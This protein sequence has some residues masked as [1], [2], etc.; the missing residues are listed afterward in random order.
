M[1]LGILPHNAAHWHVA[2]NHIPMVGF[3][4]GFLILGL[5]EFSSC[6]SW[7]KVGWFIIFVAAVFLYPVVETG[8]HAEEMV[9]KLENVIATQIHHH[10]EKAELA[11]WCAGITGVFAFIA[12]IAEA[13]RNN[14]LIRPFRL[15]ILLGVLS[16]LVFFLFA[17]YEGGLIRHPEF[18]E[19]TTPPN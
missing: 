8:E 7:R 15:I 18:M 11:V 9:S 13:I 10:E 17:A 5:S 4:F 3:F 6:T 12:F 2:L 19:L 16:S 1:D 14:Y